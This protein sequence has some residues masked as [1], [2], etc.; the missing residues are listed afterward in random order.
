MKVTKCFISTYYTIPNLSSW[1]KTKIIYF[2]FLL[3]YQSKLSPL[4]KLP[5]KCNTLHANII[6]WL[7]KYPPKLVL[8]AIYFLNSLHW[9]PEGCRQ[10][11]AACLRNTWLY[12]FKDVRVEKSYVLRGLISGPKLKLVAIY[13]KMSKKMWKFMKAANLKIPS[14]HCRIFFGYCYL[15]TYIVKKCP[16][17]YPPKSRFIP[18]NWQNKYFNYNCLKCILKLICC[19]ITNKTNKLLAGMNN[20]SDLLSY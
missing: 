19:L 16:Y 20:C 7:G 11:V 8:T 12:C 17:G 2:F 3:R 18:G 5:R 13:F 4:S 14:Y 10:Y 15:Y 9:W 1:K 6:L